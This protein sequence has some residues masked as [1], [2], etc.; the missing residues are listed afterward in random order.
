MNN[1]FKRLTTSLILLPIIFI[2]IYNSGIYFLLFLIFVYLLCMYE[3]I[4]NTKKIKFNLI[5]NFILILAFYSFYSLRGNTNTDLIFLT[6]VLLANFL[7]DIGGYLF[8][9]IFKGKKLTKIS[10]NKTYSGVI[11]SLFLSTASLPAINILQ[12]TIFKKI[13]IDYFEFKYFILALIISIICQLGDLYISYQKR[14]ISIKDI[15]NLL[16]GH[17]GIL[18]RIDGLIFVLIFIYFAKM[19]F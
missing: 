18:D 8:G 13:L 7:S 5:S 10:P 3:I 14:K 9:N 11:G 16:P 17:G 15:S 19:I 1:F 4:K 12:E 2:F 6:W